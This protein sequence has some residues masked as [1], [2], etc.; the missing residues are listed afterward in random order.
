MSISLFSLWMNERASE[1]NHFH[2][3]QL[4]CSTTASSITIDCL[5]IQT[6][7]L[8]RWWWWADKSIK[9][10]E[11]AI[12]YRWKLTCDAHFYHDKI[13]IKVTKKS[14]DIKLEKLIDYVN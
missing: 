7:V 6:T 9:K 5:N 13:L 14:K 1:K 11:T 4:I 10:F 2:N 12:T 8:W 3:A